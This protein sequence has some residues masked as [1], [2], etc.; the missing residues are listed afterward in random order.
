MSRVCQLMYIIRSRTNTTT[1]SSHCVIPVAGIHAR[2]ALR[3][4]EFTPEHVQSAVSVIS[5]R[6]VISLS[7]V[8]YF[9]GRWQCHELS[10][11]CRTQLLSCYQFRCRCQLSPK[12]YF[13]Q[14]VW[15]PGYSP[16]RVHFICGYT[17]PPLTKYFLDW[18]V[19]YGVLWCTIGSYFVF[20]TKR[21][22]S[23]TQGYRV[24]FI[25]Y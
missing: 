12:R 7:D 2:F 1:H 5:C 20:A 13:R 16:F 14:Q 9:R 21:S 4:P 15:W 6:L 8:A 17:A 24:L 19:Y 10:C 11:Y 18:L 25:R 23:R 22:H 3:C